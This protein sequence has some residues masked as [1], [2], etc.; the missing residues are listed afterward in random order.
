MGLV[1]IQGAGVEIAGG[2]GGQTVDS[3]SGGAGRSLWCPAPLRRFARTFYMSPVL[4]GYPRDDYK[5]WNDAMRHAR[6]SIRTRTWEP[7]TSPGPDSA[8][9]TRPANRRQEAGPHPPP[10]FVGEVSGKK[11]L[12]CPVGRSSFGAR[13]KSSL[14]FLGA[15]FPTLIHPRTGKR[16]GPARRRQRRATVSTNS[17][18]S[19]ATIGCFFAYQ[20]PHEWEWGNRAAPVLRV[21]R[22]LSDKARRPRARQETG[23]RGRCGRLRALGGRGVAGMGQTAETLEGV[24]G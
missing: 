9:D 16:K 23:T 12:W 19:T 5:Q 14:G 2:C 21:V 7:A 24:N 15:A 22:R 13:G 1:E 18:E 10:V 17:V 20:S 6:A 8:P 4:G 3:W 11:L